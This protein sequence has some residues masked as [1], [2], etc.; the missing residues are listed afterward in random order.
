MLIT[1]SNGDVVD[2]VTNSPTRCKACGAVMYWALTKHNR[3]APIV[4][5]PDGWVNHFI[6]CP[7][8][9]RFKKK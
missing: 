8:A 2:M 9:S 7:G 1:L 5:T 3:R 4:K 6:N